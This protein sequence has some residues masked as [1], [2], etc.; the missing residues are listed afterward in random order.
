MKGN[1]FFTQ[2]RPGKDEKIFKIKGREEEKP[3]IQLLA[4]PSDI[5]K[6]TRDVIPDNLLN[7]KKKYDYIIWFLPFVLIDPHIYWGLPKRHF[8]PKKLLKHAYSLLNEGGEMLIINQGEEEAL[9]QENLLKTLKI[10]Y[11]SLGEVENEYFE[12]KNKRFAF[13]VRK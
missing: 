11:T 4:K 9:E 6:Y 5:K 7:I 13:L 2:L 12:Y 3:L 10:S 8:N 1:P